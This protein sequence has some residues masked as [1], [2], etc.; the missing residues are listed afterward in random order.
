MS[1][2]IGNW[3]VSYLITEID[4]DNVEDE[5]MIDVTGVFLITHSRWYHAMANKTILNLTY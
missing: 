4:S 2:L 3:I 1:R 5:G